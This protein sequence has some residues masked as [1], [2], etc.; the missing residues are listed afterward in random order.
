V[1]NI[2][3]KRVYQVAKERATSCRIHVLPVELPWLGRKLVLKNVVG[4]MY[5]QDVLCNVA[6]RVL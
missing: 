6:G 2:K 1:Q 5:K 4:Y 3:H